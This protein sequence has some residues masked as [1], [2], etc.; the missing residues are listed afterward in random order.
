MP[1]ADYEPEP[2]KLLPA[3]QIVEATG[4][5]RVLLDVPASPAPEDAGRPVPITANEPASPQDTPTGGIAPGPAAT[6]VATPAPAVVVGSIAPAVATTPASPAA[7]ETGALI[8]TAAA[9]AHDTMEVDNLSEIS[10]DPDDILTRDEDISTNQLCDSISTDRSGSSQRVDPIGHEMDGELGAGKM[11]LQTLTVAP[12]LPKEGEV[13]PNTMAT[14]PSPH[15][16]GTADAGTVLEPSSVSNQQLSK[17]AG[18]LNANKE[19]KEEMDLDFEEISDGELEAE[20]SSRCRGL[21]DPLGVDWGSLTQEALRPQKP[22]TQMEQQFPV[23]ARNR[24]K[25][26]HIL[27][28]I[29]VSSL[30]V[31]HNYAQRV[32]TESKKKLREE[33]EEFRAASVAGRAA[34]EEK[35]LLL[36]KREDEEDG[37]V[38]VRGTDDSAS[39]KTETGEEER[40]HGSPAEVVVVKQQKSLPEQPESNVSSIERDLE[41]VD[42]ILH[43]VAAVHVA[44]REQARARRNL[45]LASEP[46]S[47]Q[48]Q[49]CGRALSAR[50]D[51]QIRRQLCGYPSA[52][53]ATMTTAGS[54]AGYLNQELHA[55][56]PLGGGGGTA[57]SVLH[58]QILQMYREMLDQQNKHQ[59]GGIYTHLKTV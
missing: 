17:E 4:I 6:A 50:R 29:G 16:I 10:D 56:A 48:R 53:L 38:P 12:G 46:V 37:A 54:T 32:L 57:S 30:L 39:I 49:Q 35:K 14:G 7:E 21:G 44:M 47:G 11:N 1:P 22:V 45:I 13:V 3:P 52:T 26:H 42:R 8:D 59:L 55:D 15:T 34:L 36:T 24:W 41:D 51:L 33:L 40:A 18:K 19:L 23:S 58:D 27:T 5:R 28:E 20:E 31:Y 43:P 9:D 2:T 25:S